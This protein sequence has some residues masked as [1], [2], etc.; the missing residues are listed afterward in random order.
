MSTRIRAA[1]RV[2]GYNEAALIVAN[3]KEGPPATALRWFGKPPS[4]T[5]AVDWRRGCAL[6][7]RSRDRH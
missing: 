6:F 3:R 5:C 2:L 1:W 7:G 4:G